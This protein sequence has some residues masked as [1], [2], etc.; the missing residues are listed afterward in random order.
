M[1]RENPFVTIL[2][3][4]ILVVTGYIAIAKDFTVINFPER[5]PQAVESVG[6]G[7]GVNRFTSFASSTAI[8]VT[9]SSTFVTATNTSST[10]RRISN[11]GAAAVYCSVKD[12]AAASLNTGLVVYASS[13]VEM[14]ADN[15]PY[16]GAI[17]CIASQNNTVTF[18]E[19]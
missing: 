14:T 1:N 15:N 5:P 11:L 10:Y 13:T 12:G 9:T 3:F 7:Q 18:L 6:G 4:G 2:I 8:T 19:I 17:N 16:Q